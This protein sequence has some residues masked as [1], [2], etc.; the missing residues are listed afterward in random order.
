MTDSPCPFCGPNADSVFYSDDH[1]L[2]LW[3][4][5]PASP[6]HALLV[7]RRHIP[8]WFSADPALQAALTRAI[9]IAKTEIEKA[10]NPDGYNIG[11]NVGAAAGQTVFHLHMHVIPRYAGDVP[12]P[13]GG[14]R[15][16]IPHKAYYLRAEDS[17]PPPYLTQLPHGRPVV[18]GG[19]EDPLL[20]H[21]IAHLNHATAVDIAV[22][23]TMTSGAG[24]LA[25]Y[26]E[27]VLDRGG[28]VRFLT[29]DYLGVSDPDA[30]LRLMD[31]PGDLH[32]RI[33]QSAGTSFHPKT[34]I[35]R[36][37]SGGTAFVGSSN[38]SHTALKDGVE[39]N[40][41]VIPARDQAGFADVLASFERLFCHPNV[42]TLDA[43]WVEGYRRRRAPVPTFPAGVAPEHPTAIPIPHE[44]Q[45][46]ALAALQKTRALGGSAGLVVLATGLG[47]TWLSAFDS[48]GPDFKRILFVAHRE[49]ILGQAMKTFRTIRPSAV[50]G[51]YTGTDKT[52]GAD[53]LFASIQTLSK[54]THLERFDPQ[55][56]DYII[57]DEFHHAAA[58]TYRRLLEY[59][60][61]KFLLGLTATPERTDGGD[62]LALCGETVI[63]RCDMADGIR[64]G[65]L[66]PFAYFGVPD[67][68]DYTNIPWRGNRFGEE[69]LTKAVATQVRAENILGQFRA[70]AGLRTLGFCVSQRHADFMAT[71]FRDQGLRAVAVH[72]GPQSAP[73]A[74]SL[75]Q[76]N[77]GELDILF[78][79]D[80][81]NEGVDLP[82]VDTVMMLRPTE[83]QIIWLQQF[84]RGLRWQA[85]KQLK[86]IDYIGNHRSFLLKPRTL[87]QL[88]SDSA[89]ISRALA[90]LAVGAYELPPGCSVTYELE[91]KDILLAMLRSSPPG[92]RLRA[93]YLEFRDMHGVRPTALEAFHDGYDPR[94]VR[95]AHASWLSFVRTMGDLSDVQ[96]AVV[97]RLGAFLE[98]LEKT[99]M[100]KSFKM[101][102][103]LAMLAEDAFPGAISMEALMRRFTEIARRYGL[104][105]TEVGAALEDSEGLRRLLQDNPI[106][107]WVGAKGTGGAPFFAF[108][109]GTFST[110]FD[111]PAEQRDLAHDL[112]RELVEWRLGAYLRRVE[113]AKGAD[114]ILCRVG[115]SDG[116]YVLLLP[117]RNRTAGIPEGWVDVVVD[118]TPHQANF[119][120]TAVIA[121]QTVGSDAN[122]LPDTLARWFG[123]RASKPA[124]DLVVEFVREG[125]A[126]VLAPTKGL[127]P[128][129]PRLWASYVRADVPKLFGFEFKGFES[130]SGVVEREQLILL[131]VTLDKS[132]KP[133]DQKYD[134][135]FLSAREFRWQSQNRTKRDSE[136]GRRIAEHVER[137]I[138][139]HL[140]VRAVAK[141]G[142]TTQPFVYCGPLAFE[143][144]D[145]DRPITVWWRLE[146]EVPERHRDELKVPS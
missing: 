34:Y 20:P 113:L 135:K 134:D 17:P 137:S 10:H 58:R 80:M 51:V 68:V 79:V 139:V 127:V 50:L 112:T 47:K 143:R 106:D 31:L 52:P 59:F 128:D 21:L 23:F 42:Q 138:G 136:P 121:M 75:E 130:Q 66:S 1:V 84:G 78:A 140:F 44:V 114:R 55:H 73:R 61:P 111:V 53:V 41:R 87:L 91:A 14:I 117:P 27:D 101:I 36:D 88:G 38:L 103:L 8:D 104:V 64:R 102:V 35:V 63:Y 133:D 125:S 57:V 22:A 33:F 115:L 11:L 95:P 82:R 126:Y 129:G 2:G 65:L 89:E 97:Q 99:P 100:T 110:T 77:N 13:R 43:T 24:I 85:D 16:A 48:L 141:V 9:E 26:L 118:G 98:V 120:Q 62:L 19:A 25:P 32:L 105:R 92:E 39:W 4:R 7:P 76:L 107:A 28:R 142:G 123:V 72:S 81:F 67:F 109:R 71:Y 83:S 46:E 5:F 131:F 124:S 54:A 146:Q 29:G 144:W 49:E 116:E 12:D 74:H 93:Y 18:T 145:G 90:S 30:L 6:G 56:F 3:D 37:R 119:A 108:E 60:H 122:A 94:S 86:V 69:E 45:R 70:R 132:G 40:Y 15:Y 96:V